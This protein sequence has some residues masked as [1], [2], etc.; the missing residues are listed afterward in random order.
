MNMTLVITSSFIECGI[1]SFKITFSNFSI[2]ALIPLVAK[3]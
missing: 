1:I 3:I 2:A